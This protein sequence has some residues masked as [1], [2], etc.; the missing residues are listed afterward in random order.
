[1]VTSTCA[2]LPADS[3]PRPDVKDEVL[4]GDVSAQHA[5]P[6]GAREGMPP[7]R[8]RH[9]PAVTLQG[10]GAYVA[11]P[12]IRRAVPVKACHRPIAS[13]TRGDA[14]RGWPVGC[15]TMDSPGWRG[16]GFGWRAWAAKGEGV[17]APGRLGVGRNNEAR[18]GGPGL[19]GNR[20]MGDGSVSGLSTL[21]FA[22]S[23]RR[24]QGDF[25]VF[26]SPD[27]NPFRG[28]GAAAGNPDT[29][30]AGLAPPPEA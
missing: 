11:P 5:Y 18:R 22:G 30:P 26:S 7:G 1:M 12:C 21:Y 20:P 3:S 10:V 27:G 17:E 23:G 19:G 13:R 15:L 24:L 14:T 8:L 28:A 2:L 29:S 16:G 6:G 4:A 9:P 25:G